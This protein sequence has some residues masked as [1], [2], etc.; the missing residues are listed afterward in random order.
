MQEK[1]R[2]DTH[3]KRELPEISVLEL[4]KISISSKFHKQSYY[5][6]INRFCLNLV[7]LQ[8]LKSVWIEGNGGKG[9]GEIWREEESLV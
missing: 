9:R 1:Q 5:R 2:G 7:Q 6:D 8:V 4:K 3:T